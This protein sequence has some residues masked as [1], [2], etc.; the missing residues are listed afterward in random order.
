[1]DLVIKAGKVFDP[2]WESFKELNIG[3]K[4]GRIAALTEKDLSGNTVID[5]NG[6][7]VSPGFIDIHSHSDKNFKVQENNFETSEAG[8]RMGV[9]TL[10]GGNCGVSPLNFKE[11][12][13]YIDAN[14]APNNYLG[15]MGHNTLR[16]AAGR[17]D[18]YSPAN[19]QEIEK[20]KEML[21]EN[22][23]EG[24]IGLSLGLEYTPGADIEEVLEICE[25]LKDFHSPLI[26]AHY[27]YDADRGLEAVEEMIDISRL[28]GIPMQISHL[29]S[30]ICFGNAEES[31]KV[32]HNAREE[33][34]NVMADCYP[35]N[36]FST[37][38]GS[39]VFDPGFLE[40][41]EAKYEDLLIAE[42]EYAGQY[43]T[44]ELFYK[45]R[46]EDPGT[47]LIAFVMREDETITVMKESFT[48]IATDGLV[49]NGQGHPRA[50]GT[51]P[52]VLGRYSR[53]QKALTLKE[54]LYKMTVMPARRLN[55]R[56][57]GIIEEGAFADIT[58]FDYNTVIDLADFTNSSLA[59]EGIK[60]VIVNGKLAVFDGRIVNN[61]LG[62]IL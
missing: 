33:G 2:R 30:G 32:I 34:I 48:M 46:K 38:I 6:L 40:R 42:G 27:R 41:W 51:F 19:K 21:K 36:A 50:S 58:I 15:F 13:D 31:I 52:R 47:Y 45:L 60:Y 9:T 14:G 4:H 12:K 59:P 43:C 35:Y 7:I 62:R 29:N 20:I 61:R 26:S 17:T 55:V 18:W 3:I 57:R 53:E 39:A 5:A 1:M 37:Y 16:S 49:R 8:L 24:A 23:E 25:A 54:A 10:V 56:D 44:E 22:M 11:Y 28:S